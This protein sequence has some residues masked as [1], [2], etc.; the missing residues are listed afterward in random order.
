MMAKQKESVGISR[1]SFLKGAAFGAAGAAAVGMMGACSQNATTAGDGKAT[2]VTAGGQLFEV[3][4]ADVLIIGTGNSGMAA[5]WQ[6]LKEGHTVTMIDK[7]EFRRSGASGWSWSC[8]SQIDFPDAVEDLSEHLVNMPLWQNVVDFVSS[9]YPPAEYNS[10]VY[11]I[12]HGQTAIARTEDGQIQPLSSAAINWYGKQY[13]RREMDRLT[14]FQATNIYDNTMVTNLLVRDGKCLGVT[15]VHIPTG[16]YRVFRAKVTVNCAGSAQWVYG[17]VKTK[18]VSLGGAEHTGD[19]MGI[20]YRNGLTMAELEFAKYDFI[21]VELRATYGVPIGADFIEAGH[22]TDN[23]GKPLFDDPSQIDSASK[24]A[25]GIAQAVADGRG[26]E[27]G[28]AWLTFG[29]ERM[30]AFEWKLGAEYLKNEMGI[31]PTKDP[32]EVLP[33]QFERFGGT[34]TDGTMMSQEM[35]GFFDVRAAGGVSIRP[36]PSI[37]A[38]LKLYGAYI[39]HTASQYADGASYPDTVDFQPVVDEIARLEEIRTR[40]SAGSIRP[41]VI[42]ENIQKRF[43]A[44]MSL[45][46]KKE[47][48]EEF[49]AELERIRSEDMPKMS[50]VEH[51]PNWNKEWKEAIE[52]YNLLDVA[53]MAVRATL[54]REESRYQYIR[55]D[56]P[57]RDDTNWKCYVTIKNE[58]GEM[59]LTKQDIPNL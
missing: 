32:I 29:E 37:A 35:E 38:L 9:E 48:L 39:G 16:T 26:S 21:N 57:D 52:N 55:P 47:G 45:L 14:S 15:A 2:E 28:G 59:Q 30:A 6:A 25:Q 43:Y 58:D 41:N 7:A 51:S 18:P 56:F 23:Q 11:Q 10:A 54:F 13:F 36:V 17:W 53:E 40:E 27:N 24:L 12:N 50:I 49:L 8:Y 22:F 20:C 31:D 42:R 19:I 4:D 34:L 1:R 44:N 5:A 46:R 3:Y 33:E